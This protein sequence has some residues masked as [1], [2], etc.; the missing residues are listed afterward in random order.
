MSQVNLISN[1]ENVLSSVRWRVLNVVLYLTRNRIKGLL[2]CD[3]IDCNASMGS[4][5]IALRDRA[6]ALLASSIPDL[7]FDHQVIDRKSLHFEV[8]AD[9]VLQVILES[10]LNESN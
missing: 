1:K 2:V 4:S 6:E 9:G 5:V 3:V 10:L 8:Y 7:D